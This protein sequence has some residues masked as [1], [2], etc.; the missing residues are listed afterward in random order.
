MCEGDAFQEGQTLIAFDCSIQ[1]AQLNKAKALAAAAQQTFKVNSRLAE[2]GSI[3]SLELDQSSE[4]V[5]ETEA[6]VAVMT[7]VVSKCVLKAPFTGRLAKLYVEKHQYMTPGKTLMD[8]L[9]TTQ[10]EARLIVP[11]RWLKWLKKGSLFTVRIE[12]LGRSFPAKV[13]RLGARID[14]LSQTVS[15]TGW[16]EGAHSELLP[17]MSGWAS[18]EKG[19]P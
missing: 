14:P 7:A 11:S 3:S 13:V 8:I 6:E 1:E 9:D 16:I 10:L 19:R 18:F 5:K 15:V 17:G 12:E 4:K 2:L